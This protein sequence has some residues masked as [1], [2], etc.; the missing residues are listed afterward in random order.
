MQEYRQESTFQYGYNC[1]IDY[2]RNYNYKL[3]SGYW[4]NID[5]ENNKTLYN[6]N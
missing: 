4:L 1:A 2:D 3:Y 6:L 5:I